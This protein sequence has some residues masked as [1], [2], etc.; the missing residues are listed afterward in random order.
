MT[1]LNRK[2]IEQL[3]GLTHSTIYR[4]M[5]AGKFPTPLKIGERAVRWPEHEI[6]AWLEDRPR[7]TGQAAA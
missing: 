6:K 1:L 2:D 3:T 7:A 4:L 5:R